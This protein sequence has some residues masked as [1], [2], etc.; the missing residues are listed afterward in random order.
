MRAGWPTIAVSRAPGAE[1]S[2]VGGTHRAHLL[3]RGRRRPGLADRATI[4]RE[5]SVY[6]RARHVVCHSAMVAAEV[7]GLYGIAPDK[8]VTL[9]PPID[10]DAFSL[11]A[12]SRRDELRHSLGIAPHE[13][14]LL[15]PS[16]DHVRKGG[17][18]IVQA[19][20]GGRS[21][22]PAGGC[23]QGAARRAARAQPRLPAATCRRCMR[24]PMR[25]SSLRTTRPS[26][27]SDRRRCC[28][29]RRCCSRAMSARPRCC[30][31]DACLRFERSVP[32]LRAA[33]ALALERFDAG[34]LA[35]LDD[36]GRHI[37]YPYTLAQHFEA[38]LGLLAS[39]PSAAR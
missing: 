32:A 1:L 9:Y 14:L 4:A 2:V 5:Q 29:E 28:A 8:V 13:L 33:L 20:D 39:S 6:E 19:L 10:A 15:F 25:S 23:R 24:P 22:H 26:D 34:T 12:R 11:A 18:L 16:N 3:G 30:P 38:L 35:L 21:A 17:E 27:W 36:P 37:R 7:T 31:D